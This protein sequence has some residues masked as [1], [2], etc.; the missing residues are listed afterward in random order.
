MSLWLTPSSWKMPTRKENTENQIQMKSNT[1]REEPQLK[2][3]NILDTTLGYQLCRY[4]F[5]KPQAH[6]PPFEFKCVDSRPSAGCAPIP[7]MGAHLPFSSLQYLCLPF[8][9]G[10]TPLL[11]LPLSQCR[12]VTWFYLIFGSTIWS[13]AQM[14]D[15]FSLRTSHG[16]TRP[17]P[18]S[19]QAIF[20]KM[21]H[22]HQLPLLSFV[23]YNT[24]LYS[25][26]L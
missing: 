25:R 26:P 2:V 10:N 6:G 13:L 7:P 11:F 1:D 19:S 24:N 4:I 15:P 18:F 5:L 14:S 20:P 16:A 9:I 23:W 21:T 22:Q 8:P 3:R 12:S 17:A